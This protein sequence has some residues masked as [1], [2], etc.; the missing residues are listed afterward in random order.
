MKRPSCWRSWSASRRSA[1]R[2]PCA[3]VYTPSWH[4]AVHGHAQ[5]EEA[6]LRAERV[7]ITKERAAEAA[8][9][10]AE[11]AAGAEASARDELVR[12]NPLILGGATAFQA[13]AAGLAGL[14][15]GRGRGRTP[16]GDPLVKGGAL[17][18]SCAHACLARAP[19][20]NASRGVSAVGRWL[21]GVA[22]RRLQG[23][24]G[25]SDALMRSQDT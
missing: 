7:R 19:R 9:K 15:A 1:R 10:A 12:G 16:R 17:F 13:R 21:L 8:R 2:R 25:R 4:Q 22:A 3:Q 18:L 14:R 5:D 23:C 24:L 11:E 6:E 20:N